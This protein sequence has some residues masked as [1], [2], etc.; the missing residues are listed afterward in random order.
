M[1]KISS[2]ISTGAMGTDENTR[3]ASKT[4]PDFTNYFLLV[5]QER[6][7]KIAVKPKSFRVG[8]DFW[9]N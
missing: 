2:G 8:K 9:F 7:K 4:N 5:R 6:N 1:I 3:A